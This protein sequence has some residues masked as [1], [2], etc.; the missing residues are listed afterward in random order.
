MKVSEFNT[1]KFRSLKTKWYKKLLKSGFNDIETSN[2]YLKIPSKEVLRES[3][4]S[5]KQSKEDYY[6]LADQFLNEYNFKS[7]L[8]KTI[9]EYHCNGLGSP[10]ISDTLRKARITKMDRSTIGTIIVELRE[11]MKAKYLKASE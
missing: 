6:Y 2:E 1:K 7:D 9:W 10:A 4:I 5:S 3:R 11:K 8:E